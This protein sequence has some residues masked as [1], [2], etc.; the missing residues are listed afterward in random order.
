MLQL[1]Y[2]SI[3]RSHR[4]CSILSHQLHTTVS[5]RDAKNSTE[6]LQPVKSIE[7]KDGITE[8]YVVHRSKSGQLREKVN[9]KQKHHDKKPVS[10]G[11]NFSARLRKLNT[12]HRLSEQQH[13]HAIESGWTPI[14]NGS[15]YERKTT[16]HDH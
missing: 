16:K 4:C 12:E 8:V 7:N 1:R 10:N 11:S 6:K 13:N 15:K 2:Q 9:P 5:A 3:A 14:P